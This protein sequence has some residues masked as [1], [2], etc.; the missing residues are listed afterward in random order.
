MKNKIAVITGG[1]KG[2]GYA[3]A[4]SLLKSGAKVFVCGRDKADL[5]HALER[6]SAHGQ[7][8]GEICDVRSETQVKMM[9]DECLRIF[10]GQIMKTFG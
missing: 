6:L 8:D 2:I 10:V 5:K 1:S 9:L 4:E 7:V 3:V